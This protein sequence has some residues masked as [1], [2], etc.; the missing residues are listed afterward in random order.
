MIY[1]R[2]GNLFRYFSVEKQCASVDG[3]GRPTQSYQPSQRKVKGVLADATPVEKE[4]WQQ[5]NHQITHTITQPGP[6]VAIE[7]D[8]LLYNGRV[9]YVQGIVHPGDLGLWTIYYAVERFDLHA[10]HS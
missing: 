1:L 8:R 7:G 10:I 6:P 9:F 3:H 4:Q 5:V 2:P